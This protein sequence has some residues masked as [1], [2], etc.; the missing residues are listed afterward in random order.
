MGSISECLINT[1]P[2]VAQKLSAGI[3]ICPSVGRV[4]THIHLQPDPWGKWCL[5]HGVGRARLVR[6]TLNYLF[7]PLSAGTVVSAAS[8]AIPAGWQCQVCPL[9]HSIL[10]CKIT[11]GKE[12]LPSP[13]V[14]TAPWTS[15]GG[16]GCLPALS[17]QCRTARLVFTKLWPASFH[18]SLQDSCFHSSLSLEDLSPSHKLSLERIFMPCPC[19]ARTSTALLTSIFVKNYTNL[20]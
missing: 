4:P 9:S 18:L 13:L 15:G 10:L 14:R 3:K 5:T 7:E 2:N 11:A 17:N 16:S 19:L 12:G 6:L 1:H 20:Y 8:V